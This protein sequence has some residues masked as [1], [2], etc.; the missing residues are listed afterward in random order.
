MTAG[1]EG[2]VSRGTDKLVGVTAFMDIGNCY[3]F[4]MGLSNP[5]P[6]SR[7]ECGPLPTSTQPTMGFGSTHPSPW[8]AKSSARCI[9][10]ASVV[11][12]SI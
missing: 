2:H 9:H 7:P 10:C 4:G 3:S 1:F 8:A 5:S 6:S 12:V 11:G